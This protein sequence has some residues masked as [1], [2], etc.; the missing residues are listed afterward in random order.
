MEEEIIEIVTN[1]GIQILFFI[2]IVLWMGTLVL[3]NTEP[4]EPNK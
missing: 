3:K 4:I 1:L 2:L